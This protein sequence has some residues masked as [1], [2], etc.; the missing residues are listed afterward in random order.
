MEK[1]TEKKGKTRQ[2]W[3]TLN[4]NFIKTRK[5]S[6]IRMGIGT[7]EIICLRYGYPSHG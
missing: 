7:Q 3:L 1:V 6:K 2:L 5:S 4:R